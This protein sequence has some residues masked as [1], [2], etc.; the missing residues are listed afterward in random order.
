MLRNLEQIFKSLKK[1]LNA[2]L[3][4]VKVTDKSDHVTSVIAI[5]F[6]RI[7]RLSINKIDFLC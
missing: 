7:F 1:E 3:F 6:C 5:K 2:F 4:C